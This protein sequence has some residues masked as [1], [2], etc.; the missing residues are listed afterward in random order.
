MGSPLEWAIAKQMAHQ[1]IEKGLDLFWNIDLGLFDS[2]YQSFFENQTQFLS[3]RLTIEHFR[4]FI[5]QEFKHHTIGVAIYRG[6]IDIAHKFP[7]NDHQKENIKEWLLEIGEEQYARLDFS[8]LLKDSLGGYFI[9]LFCLNAL[10][11]YLTLLA[12]CLPDSLLVYLF[13][14][15]SFCENSLSKQLAYLN[16]DR[17]SRFFLALYGNKIPLNALGWKSPSE[18]G[19][20]GLHS[21]KLP[22]DTTPSIGIC[23]PPITFYHCRHFEE[24]AQCIS[25]LLGEKRPFRLIAESKLTAEWDG[26]DY[27][28][29]CPSALTVQGKRKLQGFCAA[30]GVPV[31]S[32]D[33]MGLPEEISFMELLTL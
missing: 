14:D 24:L 33:L 30:G 10:M 12:N 1:A 5:W 13:L 16:P 15:A 21:I 32:G 20:A 22:S 9:N 6:S 17:Y 3:L 4:D 28:L 8:E 19:Y 29:F 27:L 11:E 7:L 23:I 2:F 31:T 18:M 25:K 26:L